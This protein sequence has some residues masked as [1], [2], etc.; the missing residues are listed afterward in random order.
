METISGKRFL[1]YAIPSIALG[2]FVGIVAAST[3]ATL[4]LTFI[5]GQIILVILISCGCILGASLWY[6]PPWVDEMLRKREAPKNIS[7]WFE[8]NG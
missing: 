2:L 5:Q 3:F 8:R 7:G 6:L 1:K 4:R